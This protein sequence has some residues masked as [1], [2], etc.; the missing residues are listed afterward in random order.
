MAIYGL[1]VM[2]NE[3]S[4]Y[5]ESALRQFVNV[6]DASYVFDDQSTDDSV[7]VARSVG[8]HVRVREDESPSFKDNEALFRSRALRHMVNDLGVQEGDWVLSLDADELLTCDD[9]KVHSALS[10]LTEDSSFESWDLK[11]HEVFGI[12]PFDTPYIR[13]DGFWNSISGV[14]LFRYDGDTR[15]ND[16]MRLGCGSVPRKFLKKAGKSTDLSILHYGYAEQEDRV[17]KY[18]RYFGVP[19][20]SVKHVDSILRDPVLIRWDGQKF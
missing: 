9:R 12:G 19:G 15:Y 6:V 7:E 20:H 5:L 8:S 3:S 10:T 16:T 17:T 1:T 13:L 14:R 11:V 4:R 18:A 2:K